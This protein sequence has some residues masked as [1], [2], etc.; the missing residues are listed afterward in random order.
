MTVRISASY[1]GQPVATA[2]M[3]GQI[4]R[5]I[6]KAS[7]L[8]HEMGDSFGIDEDVLFQLERNGVEIIEVTIRDK[9]E[10]YTVDLQTFRNNAVPEVFYGIKRLYLPLNCYWAKKAPRPWERPES[11]E[12]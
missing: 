9:N 2:E 12:K 1:Q 3:D 7:D 4:F 5:R 6:C 8:H 10:S 11:R